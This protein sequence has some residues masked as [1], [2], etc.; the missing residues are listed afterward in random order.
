MKPIALVVIAA[1]LT[2]TACGGDDVSTKGGASSATTNPGSP[3]GPSS[4]GTGGPTK[5]QAGWSQAVA[6]DGKAVEAE[7]S[8]TLDANGNTL[9]TW[10]TTGS[11]GSLGNEMWGARYV[12]GSGWGTPTRLDT[13]DGSHSMTGPGTIAPQLVGNAS[14]QAVAFWTEWM[15]GPDA[16]ALWARP[17]SPGAGWGTAFEVAPNVTSSTYT[18]GIDDQG[19]AIVAWP[20]SIDLLNSRIAWAR[21]TP[22]GTWSAT[23]Q[24]PMPAQTGP[25]AVTGNTTNVRPM[26]SVLP[27]G[28]A[29]LAW[30]Q[31]NTTQSAIWTATFDA[32]NGWTNVNQ[33]VSNTSLFTT[34]DTPAAG[35]DAKGNIT[36]V[37]GQLDVTGGKLLTTTMSQRYVAGSGWQAPLAVAPEITEPSAFIATPILSVNP[38][39]VAAVMWAQ[40]G[41]VLQ[42][43]VSD[44]SGNWGPLHQLTATVNTTAAQLPPL[45]IDTAGNV[46]AAWQDSGTPGSS[47]VIAAS[48]RNGSWGTPTLFGQ[49][50]QDASWPA[51]AVN[52]S[53][54]MALVW[55]SYIANAG[56]ELQAAFYTPGT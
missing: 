17:Y 27:S 10:V 54:A 22:N 44:A 9:V 2:L 29:V 23:A 1:C 33:A 55:Q 36:L 50:P 12:P 40:G 24:I 16:Y 37:W 7:P 38:N 32:T 31:T 3:S 45:V 6:M 47:D 35:M 18:A 21:Y 15:P 34:I 19:N 4:P 46:T 51:L 39:G 48:Y 26:I 11:A 42:A 14:G 49:D 56:D 52:A 43:S 25:G 5:A 20:Q 13:G 41:A 30:G 53:G 28:S 8:T